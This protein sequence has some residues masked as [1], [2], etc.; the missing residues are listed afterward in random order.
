MQHN[1]ELH[2]LNPLPVNLNNTQPNDLN[3][4]YENYPGP[5]PVKRSIYVNPNAPPSNYYRDEPLPPYGAPNPP[6]SNAPPYSGYQP[7]SDKNVISHFFGRRHFQYANIPDFNCNPK[8]I[9]T[10]ALL[11][12]L[13]EYGLIFGFS[14]GAYLRLQDTFKGTHWVIGLIFLILYLI[15]SVIQVYLVGRRLW[16]A[17]FIV[18][19]WEFAS[20]L[21]LLGWATAYL[22]F[23]LMSMSYMMMFDI[24]L[25]LFWVG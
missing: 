13:L 22:E 8:R 4:G 24:L 25:V 20:H 18:K 2:E 9:L 15:L 12:Y 3:D 16:L 14:L 17:A 21:M 10:I 19:F 1:K 11:L 6:V 23:A 7:P 5:S